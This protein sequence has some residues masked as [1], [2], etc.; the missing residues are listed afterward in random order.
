MAINVDEIFNRVR[1]KNA[2][3][4]TDISVKFK[5]NADEYKEVEDAV[6]KDDLTEMYQEALRS[7]TND[8]LIKVR[9]KNL[10]VNIKEKVDHV[11]KGEFNFD[12]APTK[13]DIAKK[14]LLELFARHPRR[15]NVQSISELTGCETQVV[16][17]ALYSLEKKGEVVKYKDDEGRVIW[18]LSEKEESLREM[19]P[20]GTKTSV[21]GGQS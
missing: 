7:L 9:K 5:V 16:Q 20:Q 12:V 17:N 13:I 19:F 3:K 11:V 21:F 18:G 6:G 2:V 4:Y 1:A 8:F 15:Y 10:Q 14:N